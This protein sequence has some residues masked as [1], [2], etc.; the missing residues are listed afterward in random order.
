M[1]YTHISG[2]ILV[3]LVL[4]LIE[5][6]A[7]LDTLLVASVIMSVTGLGIAIVWFFYILMSKK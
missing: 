5:R 4:L 3:A 6:I 2:E 1:I 7:T